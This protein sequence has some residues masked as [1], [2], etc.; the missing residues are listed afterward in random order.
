MNMKGVGMRK[1]L[2]LAV[3]AAA[4]VSGYS[5]QRELTVEELFLRDI[6]F[7]VL[8]EQAFSDDR[9]SKT[10]VLSELEGMIDSGEVGLDDVQIQFVLEYL[11]LEGT[12]IRILEGRT[13]INNFPEVRR[14]ATQLLGE[15]GSD[16]SVPTIMAILLR[17]EESMVRAEAAFS[18]GQIGS[19]EQ[20]VL[21]ALVVAVQ[22]LDP[23]TPDNTFAFASIVAFEKIAQANNGISDPDALRALV[24]L[25]QGNYFRKVRN[26][27]L[28]VLTD[29]RDY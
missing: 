21:D 20:A 7:Q 15:I 10:R 18:L 23:V 25:A 24:Q 6:E 17:D 9:E 27:A 28:Q 26:K 5:Q 3:L 8:K 1:R 22:R 16:R 11:S 29:M 12:A 19:N 2:A 13:V 14:Q 4:T